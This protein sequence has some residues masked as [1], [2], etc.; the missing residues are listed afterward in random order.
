MPLL[1]VRNCARLLFNC[2]RLL[3]HPLPVAALCALQLAEMYSDNKALKE[4]L[5][6]LEAEGSMRLSKVE[7]RL[8]DFAAQVGG[9]SCRNISEPPCSY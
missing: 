6:Q 4:H 5:Q 9:L 2:A 7:Q 3:T 8:V 1:C